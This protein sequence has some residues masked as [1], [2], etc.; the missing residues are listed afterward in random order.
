MG[1]PLRRRVKNTKQTMEETRLTSPKKF[2][3]IHLA[4]KVM[5]SF[6]WDSQWVIMI[7]YLEQGCMINDAYYASKLRRQCL[8]ISRKRRTKLTGGVLLL[9]DNAPA[10]MSQVTMTDATEFVFEI[11]P[12]PHILLISL[13]LTFIC[14]QK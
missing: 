12:H 7:D 1:S 6:F 4:G 13:L 11:L 2:K 10:D 3:R 5:V 8:D 9:Q 14:S